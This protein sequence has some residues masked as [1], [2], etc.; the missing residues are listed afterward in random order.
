VKVIGYIRVSTDEQAN[1][2]HSLAAQEAKLRA[3]A[4][5]YELDLVDLVVDA[6]Q[7]AKTLNRPGLQQALAALEAGQAEGILIAKLD[8]LTRSVRDLGHLLEVYFERRFQLMCVAEQ[9]DTRSAAGRLVANI[10]AAVGQWEREAIGERTR[11]ALQHKKAQG[12][13]LGAPAFSDAAAVARMRE[14]RA[15]GV[16]FRAVCEALTA[17]GFQT[18]KGAPWRPGVVQAILAREE[19]GV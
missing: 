18:Q 2:G 6:G 7:S 8:R 5:L 14:L 1:H 9:L 17:E 19:A 11:T 15:A 16:S 3:Y 4:E 13:K 10:L 12:C